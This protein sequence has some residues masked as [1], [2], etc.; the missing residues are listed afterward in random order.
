MHCLSRLYSLKIVDGRDQ[1][2]RRLDCRP[3]YGLS[4]TGLVKPPDLPAPPTICYLAS[5]I[6]PLTAISATV[7]KLTRSSRVL[8]LLRSDLGYSLES[9]KRSRDG[10]SIGKSLGHFGRL[11]TPSGESNLVFRS[12][13]VLTIL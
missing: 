4:L 1:A 9:F 7:S 12:L 2:L 11:T 10:S 5:M 3:S 6:Q 8:I 13:R